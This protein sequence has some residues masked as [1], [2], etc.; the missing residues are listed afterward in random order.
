MKTD[1][2]KME[3]FESSKPDEDAALAE[4]CISRGSTKG[5]RIVHSDEAP[6]WQREQ[7]ILFGY[8]VNFDT[9]SALCGSLFMVHHEMLNIWTHLLGGL[10]F[11]ACALY[12]GLFH[13]AADILHYSITNN[14][15]V[16]KESFARQ[17]K[18]TLAELLSNLMSLCKMK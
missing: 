3:K 13:K 2:K 11:L 14:V 1:F 6:A 16:L 9:W 10:F 18:D 7:F 17:H 15:E 4:E 8:R 12:W 5:P